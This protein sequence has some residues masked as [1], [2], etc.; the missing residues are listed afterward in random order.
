MNPKESK[1]GKHKQRDTHAHT[2]EAEGGILLR[3]QS[4]S[5][6]GWTM[7]SRVPS[8]I[9]PSAASYFLPSAR[10]VS[11][12]PRDTLATD[13]ESQMF[14]TQLRYERAS[15]STFLAAKVA[16]C[17]PPSQHAECEASMAAWV[18]RL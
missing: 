18:P 16:Q 9:H 12:H 1:E 6:R 10:A 15:I 7:C 11:W 17:T 8:L 13:G 3:T 2:T 14:S 4:T 5:Q